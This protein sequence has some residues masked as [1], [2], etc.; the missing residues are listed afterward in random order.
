MNP[1]CVRACELAMTSPTLPTARLSANRKLSVRAEVPPPGID[2][3]SH[4]PPPTSPPPRPTRSWHKSSQLP[5]TGVGSKIPGLERVEA[6]EVHLVPMAS[7]L[8][9]LISA[10]LG[11]PSPAPRNPRQLRGIGCR[12]SHFATAPSTHPLK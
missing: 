4:R 3:S 12:D 8:S 6:V 5:V 7:A 10:Y 9:P 1:L 2:P 11:S